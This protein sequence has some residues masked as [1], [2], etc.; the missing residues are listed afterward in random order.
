MKSDL[1]KV[2]HSVAGKAL[3]EHV[4]DA[5][6]PLGGAVGV[7]LGRGADLVKDRLASAKGPFVFYS[8][9]TAGVGGRGS[10]RRP[11]VGEA[12]RGCPGFVWGRSR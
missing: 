8:K 11:L 3:V 1:P 7:V 10:A 6:A 9:R 2:L 4:L 5:V 12:G